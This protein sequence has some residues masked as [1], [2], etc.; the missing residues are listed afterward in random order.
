MTTQLVRETMKMVAEQG[1]DPVEM[2][3]FDA[4]GCI[5]DRSS[6]EPM[7]LLNNRPPFQRCMVCF[8]GQ[9]TNHQRMRMWVLV[10]GDDPEE[11]IVLTAWR[12]PLDQRPVP[13]PMMFYMIDGNQVKYGPVDENVTMDKTEAA[14]ILGFMSAWY[15]ALSRRSEAYIPSVV[16]NFTNRRKIAQGKVPAYDWRTVVIEPSAPRKDHQ[17]GTHA[18]PRLHDRR[19]HLRRL[20]SGKNV[21][22]R[23]CKVGDATK[24]TV[25]HDYLVKEV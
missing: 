10:S 2:H 12:Q 8:E 4:T 5:Q 16:Q 25:F 15:D 22:V 18:S 24:G 6:Q 13:S 20:R 21:W 14:M 23:S 11:G 17:G 1:L 7:P 3:W 9:S 19:G